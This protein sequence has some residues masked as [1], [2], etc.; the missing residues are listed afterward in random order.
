MKSILNFIVMI[1]FLFIVVAETAEASWTKNAVE[2]RLDKGG[3]MWSFQASVD[4]VA[5]DTS[6]AFTFD[7]FMIDSTARYGVSYGAIHSST[8][9]ASLIKVYIQGSYDASNW[10]AVQTLLGA[11]D[12]S[13]VETYQ[14]GITYLNTG[15][16]TGVLQRFPYYRVIIDGQP[17]NRSDCVVYLRLHPWKRDL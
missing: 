11:S 16:P 9:G 4:S 15:N 7:G 10:V 1:S 12:S 6:K 3:R 2:V 5:N 13:S 14:T 17:G 8:A